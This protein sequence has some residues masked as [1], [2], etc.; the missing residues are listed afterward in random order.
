ME[1]IVYRFLELVELEGIKFPWLEEQTQIEAARWRR[2]KARKVMRTSELEAVQK[3]YP[4]YEIWLSTG[5][6]IPESGH[7][8]PMTKKAQRNLKTRPKVG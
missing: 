5:I 1:Q 8:S 3:V 2:I 4:E 6:E 7:I